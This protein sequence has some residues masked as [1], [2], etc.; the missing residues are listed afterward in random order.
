MANIEKN[1]R[2]QF[3]LLFGHTKSFPIVCS[4]CL[5]DMSHCAQVLNKGR[6]LKTTKLLL[7]NNAKA[8]VLQGVT[9][10]GL[11]DTLWMTS[12]TSQLLSLCNLAVE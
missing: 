2:R 1:F 5:T 7:S 10:D 9:F 12:L 8:H 6:A 3:I 4:V 11:C